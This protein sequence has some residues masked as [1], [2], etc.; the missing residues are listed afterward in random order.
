MMTTNKLQPPKRYREAPR[1]LTSPVHHQYLRYALPVD[2]EVVQAQRHP[3][4]P[5]EPDILYYEY[6]GRVHDVY[7]YTR[8]CDGHKSEEADD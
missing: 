6:A 7:I 1:M 4:F 8:E 3:L 2:I 5:P